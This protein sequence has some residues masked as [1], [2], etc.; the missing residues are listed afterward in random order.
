M[1]LSTQNAFFENSHVLAQL[2][3]YILFLFWIN[4]LNGLLSTK[5]TKKR[6]N[7]IVF[8]VDKANIAEPNIAQPVI[9]YFG[10][11]WIFAFNRQS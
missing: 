10:E 2:F 4:Q 7:F 1:T 9:V 8:Q 3:F 6:V 5:L 11:L